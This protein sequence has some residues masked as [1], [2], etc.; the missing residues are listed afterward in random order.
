[1]PAVDRRPLQRLQIARGLPRSGRVRYDPQQMSIRRR[2]VRKGARVVRHAAD[3]TLRGFVNGLALV[4]DGSMTPIGDT[5]RTRILQRGK[6]EVWRYLPPHDDAHEPDQDESVATTR[7]PVPI[8]LV[9]PLMVRPYIYDL[10]PEHS[11]VRFF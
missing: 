1:R 10:R 7:F 9:P 2:A 6:L 8:L 11:M 3:R 4:M 5:S